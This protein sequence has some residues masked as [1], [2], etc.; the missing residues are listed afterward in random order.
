M[1]QRIWKEKNVASTLKYLPGR[2][3]WAA[4]CSRYFL[5]MLNANDN[6]KPRGTYPCQKIQPFR[7]WLP[8]C[9]L[10]DWPCPTKYVYFLCLRRKEWASLTGQYSLYVWPHK[11]SGKGLGSVSGFRKRTQT[12]INPS[13]NNKKVKMM[14]IFRLSFALPQLR[15]T[16]STTYKAFRE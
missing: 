2:R 5:G 9:A 1:I 3:E 6:S 16:Y 11:D 14:T 4:S 7:M 13:A 8:G 10:P 15:N 12:G